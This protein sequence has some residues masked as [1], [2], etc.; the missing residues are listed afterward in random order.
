MKKI[1]KWISILILVL[2]VLLITLPFLFKDKIVTKIKAEANKTLQA[3]FDF[4]D[5][6]F[7]FF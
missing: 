6:S 3:K 5:F 7:L 1:I 2:L 4:G